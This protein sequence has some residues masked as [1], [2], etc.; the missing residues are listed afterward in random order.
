MST[1]VLGVHFHSEETLRNLERVAESLG[2]SAD[3]L[4]E[5]AIEREFAAIG[6]GLEERLSRAFEDLKTYGP[7]DLERDLRAN[8][9]SEVEAVSKLQ[10]V[11]DLSQCPLGVGALLKGVMG[12]TVDPIP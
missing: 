4:A 2:V 6:S 12:T 7:A 1:A 3:Q 10:P 9:K 5:V 8:G 11:A